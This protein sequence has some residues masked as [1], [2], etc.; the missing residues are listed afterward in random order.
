MKNLRKIILAEDNIADVELTKIAFKELDLN[1]DVSHVFDGQ[2]LMDLLKNSS[3][4]EV[5]L[6]L[7]DLNMPKM[8]GIEFLTALKAN[9]VLKFIPTVILTTSNNHRDMIECYKIGI[10]GYILKP[11]KYEEYRSKI[12][13]LLNYWSLNELKST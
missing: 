13:A 2:Q 3:L 5:A 8:N 9:D 4:N 12:K 7:L 6:V 1:L 11:L 10:A